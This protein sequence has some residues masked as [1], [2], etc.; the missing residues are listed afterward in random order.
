MFPQ[1]ISGSNDLLF[2]FWGKTFYSAFLDGSKRT[3]REATPSIW[4]LSPDGRT[5][6]LAVTAFNEGM[7]SISPD[8]QF[9]AYVSDESGRQEVYAIP[10]SGH[11]A[12][13]SIS[14]EGGTGPVWS[15]DGQELFY[16]SGDDLVS[17]E[18]HTARGLVVGARHRLLD[19]SGYDSG[20]FRDPGIYPIEVSGP[21]TI[22]SRLGGG[23][24]LPPSN[25]NGRRSPARWD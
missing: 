18:V 10:A 12:R 3:W 14:L 5:T 11:G 6:P 25:P 8:G 24:N 23:D 13:V 21:S 9:V 22:A 7:A 20:S 1:S 17:V 19:L 4:M 15:R 16:R 2:G